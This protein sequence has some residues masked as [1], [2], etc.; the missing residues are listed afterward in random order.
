[1]VGVV[2]F[3]NYVDDQ[4]QA[5]VNFPNKPSSWYKENIEEIKALSGTY[6]DRVSLK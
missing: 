1:M 5:S 6:N 4:G 2:G 3:K